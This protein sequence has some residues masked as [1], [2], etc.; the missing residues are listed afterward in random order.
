MN[1]FIRYVQGMM[2]LLTLAASGCT[3]AGENESSGGNMRGYNHVPGQTVNRFSVNG[4][5]GTLTG[6]ICCVMLPD[7]WRPGLI[8]HVEWEVDPQTAPVFPGYSDRTKFLAW[9]KQVEGSY[10]RHSADVE[11]PQYD[12]SGGLDVH[13]LPCNK[14]KVYAGIDGFGSPLYPIKEPMNMKEPASCPK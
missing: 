10:Q 9:K 6:N 14:V 8:A 3:Q 5:G 1:K 12:K 4:Y 11:I 7:K 13:F 2:L